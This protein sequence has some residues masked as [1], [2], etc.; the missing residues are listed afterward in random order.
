MVLDVYDNS[1]KSLTAK[2]AKDAKEKHKP[3]FDLY[4]KISAIRYIISIVP[5][6]Q[7]QDLGLLCVLRVLCGSRIKFF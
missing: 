2:D 3:G 1:E 7:R 4:E 6:K 5:W